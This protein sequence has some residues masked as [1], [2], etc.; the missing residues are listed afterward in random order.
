MRDG[1]W[2]LRVAM[3]ELRVGMCELQCASYELQCASC[4]LGSAILLTYVTGFLPVVGH[5]PML[6]L[7]CSPNAKA[8]TT[9]RGSY[10]V[11]GLILPI[12]TYPGH[13]LFAFWTENLMKL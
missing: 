10:L 2:D 5:L 9:C 7:K 1:S 8:W 11:P 3:C 12:K 13:L 6:Q 4:E